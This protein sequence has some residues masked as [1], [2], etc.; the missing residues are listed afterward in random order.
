MRSIVNVGKMTPAKV[1]E[2]KPK[3]VATERVKTRESRGYVGAYICQVSDLTLCVES[4]TDPTV[5]HDVEIDFTRTP[6]DHIIQCSCKYFCMHRS[7]C[8]HIALVEMEAPPITF[9]HLDF[10]N[11]QE[12][13]YLG[14]LEPEEQDDSS[15]AIPGV[16]ILDVL[17]QRFGHLLEL[18]DKNVDYPQGAQVQKELEQTVK[19]FEATFSR[20]QG[21]DLNSKRPRQLY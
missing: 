14:M 2:L 20:K 11:R 7:W 13:L 6:T 8:K 4:F 16:D 10:W 18:R 21:Q 9:L 15:N 19:L 17:V 3:L 1:E 12:N 5:A